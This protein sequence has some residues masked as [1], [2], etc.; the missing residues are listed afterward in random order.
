MVVVD[1]PWFDR[2]LI[3]I[4]TIII[5]MII[6]IVIIIMIIIIIVIIIIIIMSSLLQCGHSNHESYGFILTLFVVFFT[7]FDILSELANNSR[8]SMQRPRLF[9]CLF[10]T[11]FSKWCH[12]FKQRRRHFSKSF[13]IF[14]SNSVVPLLYNSGIFYQ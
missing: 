13:P 9:S 5:I 1:L 8:E 12:D 2:E 3:I 7:Y 4:T 6:I 10:S 14:L 11:L